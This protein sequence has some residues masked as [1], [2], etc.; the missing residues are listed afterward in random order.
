MHECRTCLQEHELAV[1]VVGIIE[2]QE[3]DQ[4]VFSREERFFP[5]EIYRDHVRHRVDATV[6][7]ED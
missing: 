4:V 2:G 7:D 1:F 5:S 3:Q 6:P